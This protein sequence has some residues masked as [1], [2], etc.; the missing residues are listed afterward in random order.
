MGDRVNESRRRLLVGVVSATG[1]FG[2]A[3]AAYPFIR[4]WQ[5]SERAKALGAPVEVEFG[6][7]EL[8]GMIR[9]MWRGKPV[10]IVRRTPELLGQL[11][12]IGNQLVD[13]DSLNSDQPEYAKNVSRARNPEYLVV[14]GVCTHLSCAPAG[15][16]T[17]PSPRPDVV[18]IWPG[19]FFCACHGSVYDAAGR[20]FKGV[21]APANLPIPPYYFA[22]PTRVVVGLS[23]ASPASV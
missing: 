8:G 15:V 10:F 20:V 2:V 9:V 16:L 11:A 12:G 4:S 14:T 13:P 6:A 22:A 21:P 5:P 19:G 3:S 7:L 17:G 23:E 18:P 1:C